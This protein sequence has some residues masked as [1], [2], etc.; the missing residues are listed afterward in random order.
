MLMVHAGIT[1]LL[2]V[3]MCVGSQVFSALGGYALVAAGK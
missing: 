2:F 1:V 3:C